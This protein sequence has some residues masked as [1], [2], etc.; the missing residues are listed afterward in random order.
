MKYYGKIDINQ[1]A[2]YLLR[3]PSREINRRCRNIIENYDYFDEVQGTLNSEHAKQLICKSYRYKMLAHILPSLL[4][5]SDEHTITDEVFWMICHYIR[6]DVRRSMLVALAH[7]P[8][9]IYQ[10]QSICEKNVCFEAFATLLYI[11]ATNKCFTATDLKVLICENSRYL[12]AIDIESLLKEK[13][14]DQEKRTTL[15][16]AE[17]HYCVVKTPQRRTAADIVRMLSM[18]RPRSPR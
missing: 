6:K 14:I 5:F 17:Q 13:M 18:K 12:K 16:Y 1:V 9:S 7:C 15:V 2:R 3:L 8:I 11:Y 10:L 4:Y